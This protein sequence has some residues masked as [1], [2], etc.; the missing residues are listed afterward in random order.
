[1]DLLNI[2]LEQYIPYAIEAL[3]YAYGEQYRSIITD[4]LNNTVFLYY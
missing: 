3:T 1:M 4:R 2:K